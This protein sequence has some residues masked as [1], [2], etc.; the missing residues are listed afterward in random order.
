MSEPHISQTQD[1]L[2]GRDPQWATLQYK[3]E[4]PRLN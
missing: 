4:A 2:C 3:A 1:S